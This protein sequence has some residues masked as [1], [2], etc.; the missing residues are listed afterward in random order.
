VEHNT[1]QA[2]RRAGWLKQL[3][4]WH[5]ISA[6]ISLIGLLLFS[7]TGITLNHAGD[8]KHKPRVE[9]RELTLPDSLRPLLVIADKS[10]DTDANNKPRPAPLPATV[11]DWLS[12]T[13]GTDVARQPAEWSPEEVYVPLPRP[14]GDAWLRIARDDG[15]I[16]Y[17]STDQGWLAYFNDLHKGRNTGSVWAWFIDIFAVACLLSSLT[18]LLILQFHAGQRPSTWP[19]VGLGLVIPLIL[20]LL[21]IH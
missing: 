2:G 18:G 14:G 4:R 17:E 12:H 7:V 10:D 21:F 8:I 19:L 6:A 11:A 13:L 20:A 3:H 9:H 16:E 5:W 15:S 1:H